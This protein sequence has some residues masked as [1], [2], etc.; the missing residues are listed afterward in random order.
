M[1]GRGPTAKAS[2][3]CTYETG[4]LPD[5]GPVVVR[6]RV[7]YERLVMDQKLQVRAFDARSGACQLPAARLVTR[8]MSHGRNRTSD[9]RPSITGAVTFL[10][11]SEK[12]L[13]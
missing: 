7:V 1:L 5:T 12:L 3:W 4:E 11:K 13:G 6:V 8:H 2:V 10:G 9:R